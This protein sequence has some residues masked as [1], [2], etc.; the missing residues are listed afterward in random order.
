MRS[1]PYLKDI[2]DQEQRLTD[3]WH[4][5][6]HVESLRYGRDITIQRATMYKPSIAKCPN[7]T[8]RR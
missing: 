6:H 1:N 3:L 5:H 8:E 7:P 2:D 4:G